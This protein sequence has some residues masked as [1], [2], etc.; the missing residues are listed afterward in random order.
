MLNFIH[1]QF[2]KI[3][4]VHC[5]FQVCTGTFEQTAWER[6]NISLDFTGVEDIAEKVIENRRHITAALDVDNFAEAY[7]VHGVH[8]IFNPNPQNPAIA[9]TQEADGLASSEKRLALMVKSADCQ[10]ILLADKSGT[11]IAALHAG[12]KGNRQNYPAIAVQDFCKTF[13]LDPKDIFA[14]RGPSLGPKFAEFKNFDEEWGEEFLPYFNKE[15]KTMDLW[16][17]TEDQLMSVGVPKKNIFRIDICTC[18]TA[19]ITDGSTSLFS[20]RK[21]AIGRQ[22]S[23]IWKD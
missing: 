18:E 6:G 16:K 23:F 1:F 21:A 8:T 19:I 3:N 4:N 17:L 10:P 14:V 22:G 11:Y 9:A 5:A 7:Q 20:F 15:T 2:P 12:W 13:G